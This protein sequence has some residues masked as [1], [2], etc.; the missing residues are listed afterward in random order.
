MQVSE[1]R[2]PLLAVAASKA[3]IEIVFSPLDG[4]NVALL[5]WFCVLVGVGI[6]A[7][8]LLSIAWATTSRHL[9]ISIP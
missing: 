5:T 4:T 1:M 8:S 9:N 2:V 6:V 7:R 3:G